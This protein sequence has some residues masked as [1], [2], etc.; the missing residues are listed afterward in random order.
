MSLELAQ[1]LIVDLASSGV[2]L[3]R[4]GDRLVTRGT[5]TPTDLRRIRKMKPDLL[6]AIDEQ[7]RQRRLLPPVCRTSAALYRRMD[8]PIIALWRD[9]ARVEAGLAGAVMANVRMFPAAAEYVAAGDFDFDGPR[10][11]WVA[12]EVCHERRRFDR[13][14]VY[15]LSCRAIASEMPALWHGERGQGWTVAECVRALLES[16]CWSWWTVAALMHPPRRVLMLDE[17]GRVV[18]RDEPIT[19]AD[20]LALRLA[21]LALRVRYA[22]THLKLCMAAIRGRNPDT[23]LPRVEVKGEAVAVTADAETEW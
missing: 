15:R 17:I 8:D 9:K 7:P 2:V 5:L 12:A 21:D 23:D 22:E 13:G 11:C 16:D 19:P 20:V 14:I 1:K 18:A 10:L 3:H 4:E 6:R